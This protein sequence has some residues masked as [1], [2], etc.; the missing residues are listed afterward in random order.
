MDLGPL[1]PIVA[2]LSGLGWGWLAL[3]HRELKL[4][5]SGS[6]AE[7]E[8]LRAENKQLHDRLAVLERIAT[9]QPSAL[10]REIETLR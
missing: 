7:I 2:I 6:K 1:I 5:G 8:T 3:K 10:S 9:D 4:K